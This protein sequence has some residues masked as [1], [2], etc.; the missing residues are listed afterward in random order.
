MLCSKVL[1]KW[2]ISAGLVVLPLA[3]GHDDTSTPNQTHPGNA[4]ATAGD[5]NQVNIEEFT[6]A[7][8]DYRIRN[9]RA[10][11]QFSQNLTNNAAQNNRIQN[12]RGLGHFYMGPGTARQNSAWNYGSTAAVLNGWHNSSGHR[13]NMLATGL[14]CFGIHWLG[15]YWT[16]DLGSC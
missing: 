8:N 9:G 5:D 3:C 4:D 16:M 6:A 1:A 11:L 7:F 14:P 2:I 15:A 10:A 13:V 12:A